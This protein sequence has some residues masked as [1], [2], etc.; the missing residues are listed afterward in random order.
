[1]KRPLATIRST[2][3]GLAC[4][5]SISAAGTALAQSS[6][7]DARRHFEAGMSYF[8]TSEY[9]DALREFQRSY[10]LSEASKRPAILRNIAA[11]YERMGNLEKT[12]ETLEQYLREDPNTEEKA[13]VELRITNLKERIAQQDKGQEEAIV[14][15]SPPGV[16]PAKPEPAPGPAPI[17]EQPDRTPAYVAWGVGGAAAVGA[18]VT[19]LLANNR[20]ND[21]KDGCG[22]TPAG[23]SDDEISGVTSMAWISTGLT[24]LAVVGA[25]VGTVLYFMAEPPAQE[26]GSN[27]APRVQAGVSPKGGGVEAR[28]TF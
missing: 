22:S 28:W 2:M 27:W 4:A 20:Y 14:P 9:E 3:V 24:G 1:M 13:T 18:V 11:V 25:G 8:N 15:P 5:L 19:G 10:Q 6:D 16:E 12:V 26:Q 23:C 21:R 17:P 7:E